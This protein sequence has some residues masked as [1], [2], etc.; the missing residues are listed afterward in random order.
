[1]ITRPRPEISARGRRGTLTLGLLALCLSLG[2]HACEDVS[3][4]TVEVASVSVDPGQGTLV[5]GDTLRL[6]ATARDASGG[7]LSGRP[8]SWTSEN[9]GVATVS[10]SGLVEAHAPGE[11]LIRASS[12]GASGTAVITVLAAPAIAL[13]E[14]EV[15]FTGQAGGE[16][17]SPRTVQVTNAGGGSL[18]GLTVQVI[19]E[20]AGSAGWL[21]A[22]LQTTTAPAGLVLVANPSQLTTGRYRAEVRVSAASASNSPVTLDVSFD[23]EEA[24]PTIGLATNA[25]GFVWEEGQ[26]H[27]GAQTIAVT[28]TGGGTLRGLTT[29]VRHPQGT[30]SGWLAASV[31]AETAP[32]QLRL[33]VD[34]DDLQTGVYDAFVDV[35]AQGATNSP[36]E[37]RVRLTVGNPPPELELTPASVQ[38]TTEEGSPPDPA[39][40]SVQVTNRGSGTLGGLSASVAYT[41]GGASGWLTHALSGPEAPASLQLTAESAALPPGTYTAAVAVSSPDAVNSPQSVSVELRVLPGVDAELS[42]IQADPDTLVANGESTSL[43]TVIL[44]DARGAQLPSGGQEVVLSTTAGTLGALVDH[45]N[46]THTATLTAPTT[47]GT[48]VVTGTV[49]GEP[50]GDAA[51]VT[52]MPG[53]ASPETSLL[54]VDPAELVA[55]GE[56]EAKVRVELRDAFQNPLD[57]GGDD[58]EVTLEGE[59]TLGTL[60]DGGDGS[61]STTL[62]S[63]TST[64]S[65]SVG[66]SVNGEEL[67]ASVTVTY[68]ASAP[69]RITM[70]SGD[71]QTGTVGE[72]LG[73]ALTV[74][75]EDQFGNRVSGATVTWTPQAG[76]ASPT[77]STTNPAGMASTEWTLGTTAGT[78]TLAASVEGVG[79][80]VTF[81][82]TAEP[83]DPAAI[84]V[85]AGNNQTGTVGGELDDPLEVRVTDQY[86]NPVSGVSV[87]W[88]PDQGS[89]DPTSSATDAQGIATTSWT[90]GI[91]PGTQTLTASAAGQSVQFSATAV[92]AAPAAIV[93]HS[94]NNQTGTVGEPLAQELEARVTDEFGNPVSGVSVSWTPADG[95]ANPTSS[96][97]DL[98]GIAATS[99]TLGTDPGTQTLTA[100]A[101]GQSVQFSATAEAGA[102]AA[103]VV[104]SGNNQT[105]T[106]GEELDDPLE[107]VVADQYGNPVPGVSV[108]WTP[109]DGSANPT[110][111]A[112]DA[113]GVAA[114]A[115]T[116]GTDPGTQTLT[117]SAAGQSV[118]F[119][120]TAEADEDPE[121]SASLSAQASPANSS[122][123]AAYNSEGRADPGTATGTSEHGRDTE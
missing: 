82:A 94:G 59:G 57:T 8:V 89:A 46:G 74:R 87:S 72:K 18:T 88:S 40:Q 49:D 110:S 33:V 53:P 107:V 80:P 34:P 113:Q 103:I 2:L 121:P 96:T 118:Q 30:P 116:L 114:T 9:G 64:G 104:H 13:S 45:G 115:W 100:S 68:V 79:S 1:M 67:A 22:N 78:Q 19:Y 35:S 10:S 5:P 93:V 112:T 76:S 55:D 123:R 54:T 99:W 109:A 48:G 71:E 21:S 26:P 62:T 77:T 43:I 66:A 58:V 95:S 98:L 85:H 7:A 15:G 84:M 83:D 105:G 3:V 101:G 56:S 36:Q 52:F 37:V 32:T 97:T 42:E 117:A 90:L 17:A 23:V 108:S 122:T 63:P 29:S 69:G 51:E 102:V 91:T 39:S 75:V 11:A 106:V 24:P 120:A 31:D 65:A 38:W 119:S 28:N 60:V 92:V 14:S 81:T 86:G 61:Y 47:V 50:I 6:S 70:R 25:I 44:R 111:S 41:G 20:D 16:P 27:P 4:T 73:E 12:E